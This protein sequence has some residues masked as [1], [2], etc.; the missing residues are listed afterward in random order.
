MQYLRTERKAKKKYQG[1]FDCLLKF[2]EYRQV[3]TIDLLNL[4]LIDA[5]RSSWVQAGIGPK[6]LYNETVIVRQLVNFTLSRGSIHKDPLKG[7]RLKQ[8]TPTPQPCWTPEEVKRILT[9]SAEPE[10]RKFMTLADTGMR[11]GE[12][13]FLSWGDVDFDNN[14]LRVRP[15]DDWQPKSGDQRSIPMTSRV[16][17]LLESLPRFGRWVFTAAR[18]GKYRQRRPSVFRSPS[19]DIAQTRAQES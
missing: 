11:V 16:R 10:R 13:R 1:I 2:T 9:A 6:T 5:Y 19:F 3:R 14:L 7:L 15:K 8:P 4:K 12:L 17:A 18:S